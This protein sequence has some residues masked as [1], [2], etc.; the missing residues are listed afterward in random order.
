MIKLLTQAYRFYNFYSSVDKYLLRR[1]VGKLLAKRRAYDQVLE[2]G[3]GTA[4]MKS[5]ITQQ[6]DIGRYLLSDV[7]ESDTADVVCDAQNMPFDKASFDLLLAFEVLEHI[8]DPDAFFS[9]IERVLTPDGEVLL[10]VPFIY[11]RHDFQDFHRWTPQGLR[12]LFEKHGLGV[13]NIIERGGTALAINRLFVNFIHDRMRATKKGWRA[14]GLGKKV[15]FAVMTAALIPVTIL[16][17]F[18]L[19]FDIVFDRNSANALGY[20]VIAQKQ[21][22]KAEA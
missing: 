16:S 2:I 12:Q 6:S 10:S 20:V 18:A 15:Y 14:K 22:A 21:G 3:A 11:G 9:E 4:M 8:P 1:A 5:L 17:W 19:V 13:Q 7:E